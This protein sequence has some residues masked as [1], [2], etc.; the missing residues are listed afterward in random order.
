MKI[1]I[2]LP[3]DF[4][5]EEMERLRDI[6]GRTRDRAPELPPWDFLRRVALDAGLRLDG[7]RDPLRPTLERPDETTPRDVR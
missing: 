3:S 5:A 2:N 4:S 6:W 1:E 7:H